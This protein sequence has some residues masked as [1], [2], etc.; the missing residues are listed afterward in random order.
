MSF[1]SKFIN[2]TWNISD[3]QRDK[4]IPLPENVEAFR[5]ISYAKDGDKYNLC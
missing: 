1:W 2:F 3:T 5:N 4:K